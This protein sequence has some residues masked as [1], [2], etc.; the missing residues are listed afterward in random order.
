MVSLAVLVTFGGIVGYVTLKLRHDIQDRIFDR[1]A[2]SV[3]QVVTSEYRRS[4]EAALLENAELIEMDLIDLALTSEQIIDKV[5]LWCL[6]LP[7]V[8]SI[9]LHDLE[10]ELRHGLPKAALPGSLTLDERSAMAEGAPQVRWLQ[11]SAPDLVVTMAFLPEV[12]SEPVGYARFLLDGTS[13]IDELLAL[14]ENLWQQAGV[15]FGAGGLII[16]AILWLSFTRL[17][18]SSLLL[19]E[20]SRRLEK[21]NDQLVLASK[22]A[23][24]GSVTAHLMHSLKNPLAGLREYVKDRESNEPDDEV[25]L[26]SQAARSMQA[27]VEEALQVLQEQRTE[28]VS[29]AF[30]AKEMLAI[31]QKRLAPLAE[32]KGVDL[33]FP[34]IVTD[35]SIDNLKANLL[36]LALFNLGQ[37]AI[38]ATPAGGAVHFACDLDAENGLAFQVDDGGPGLPEDMLDAPFAPRVSR[39]QGGT[40]VGLAISQQLAERAGAELTL[41]NNGPG[42]ACFLLVASL[43]GTLEDD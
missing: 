36:V 43:E 28:G 33:H 19:A 15:A 1:A 17:Q 10:G 2:R 42:G 5:A 21:A 32:N 12:D 27:M 7:G 9:A 41:K 29:Y 24:L 25:R 23:A 38:E 11:E 8:Q 37:N 22:S 30:T 16:G 6:E 3:E 18:R 34:E 39:K 26:V 4:E 14:D 13:I 35:V 31:L 40:G 20:R